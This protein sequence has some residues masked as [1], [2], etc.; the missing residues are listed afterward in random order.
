[1]M[2]YVI[3]DIAGESGWCPEREA[4][5]QARKAKALAALNKQKRLATKAGTEAGKQ[6]KALSQFPEFTG[7]GVKAGIRD[8][9]IKGYYKGLMIFKK[10]H[11]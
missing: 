8:A 1:M 7:E 6:S 2:E 10:E 3:T 11:Q 4:K 5:E 9:F